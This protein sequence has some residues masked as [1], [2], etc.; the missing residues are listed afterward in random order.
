MDRDMQIHRLTAR[1]RVLRRF[2]LDL[3]LGFGGHFLTK[4]RHY[5]LR[6]RDLRDAR[7]TYRRRQDPGPEHGPIRTI[8][9][10]E[11]TLITFTFTYAG[12]GGGHPA[13]LRS[14]TPP[15]T[16][17]ANAAKPGTTNS[18]TNTTALASVAGPRNPP[19]PTDA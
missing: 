7:I 9:D 5:S 12:T 15:P 18:P 19:V 13:M 2:G 8:D 14:P 6:F 3:G 17:H 10:D 11:T 16:R 4:A 1:L